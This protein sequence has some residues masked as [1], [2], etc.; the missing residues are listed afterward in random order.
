MA[1]VHLANQHLFEVPYGPCD[2]FQGRKDILHQL[3]AYFNVKKSPY[4]DQRIFAICGLGKLQ[5]ELLRSPWL[6][7]IAGL[8][9]ANMIVW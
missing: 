9:H 1:N 4:L 5:F 8:P 3:D 7:P 2:T 6:Y